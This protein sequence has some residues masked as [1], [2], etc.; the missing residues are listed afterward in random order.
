MTLV[1]PGAF[2]TDWAGSSAIKEAVKIDDY[3]NTVGANIAASAKTIDTK[4]GNPVLAAKAIIKAATADQP[5]LHLILGK[6]AFVK[7]H[8]QIEYE[9]ADLNNWKDVSRHTDFGN[10][11]FWK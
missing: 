5:P 2:R 1:E 9:L 6:D 4:P 8:A 3:Q 10:E 11:D 7:A